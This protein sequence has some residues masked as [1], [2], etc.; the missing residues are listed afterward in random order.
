M[1]CVAAELERRRI[2]DRTARGHADAKADRV[3][4]AASRR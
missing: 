2:A 4:L 1:L 3:K